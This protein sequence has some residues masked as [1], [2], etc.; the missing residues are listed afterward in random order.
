MS[1]RSG[2]SNCPR[3]GEAAHHRRKVAPRPNRRYPTRQTSLEWSARVPAS[4][5]RRVAEQSPRAGGAHC[6]DA[7]HGRLLSSEQAQGGFLAQRVSAVLTVS[8]GRSCAAHRRLEQR[9]PLRRRGRRNVMRSSRVR[10]SFDHGLVRRLA[11]PESRGPR[12]H[13]VQPTTQQRVSTRPCVPLALA[14][15]AADLCT[16]RPRTSDSRSDGSFG[17]RYRPGTVGSR[18][19]SRHREE[20]PRYRPPDRHLRHER[21]HVADVIYTISASNG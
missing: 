8:S 11:Q 5:A 18:R 6:R 14:G 20:I 1:R 17:S 21:H 15:S 19:L 16:L 9:Q 7:S 4:R 2:R 3:G 12:I 10:V 13:V